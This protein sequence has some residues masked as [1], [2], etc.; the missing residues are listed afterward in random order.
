MSTSSPK[1]VSSAAGVAWNLSALFDAPDDPRIDKSI[2][3]AQR[4]AKRF[5]ATW[6]GKIKGK[7][8]AAALLQALREYESIQEDATRIGA[9]AHLVFAADTRPDAHRQLLQRVEAA[10]T[11]LRNALLFFD[12]EWLEVPEA[13]VKK[14]LADPKLAA[15]KHYLSSERKYKPHT[16]SEPEEVLHNEK[17]M[18]G[19]S[20][21]QKLHTELMAGM[22]FPVTLNGETRDLNQ[23]EA[24]TLMRVA[25]RA[26]RRAAWEGFYNVLSKN[27]QV[28]SYIY[29]TRFNDYLINNRLR[30]FKSHAQPRHLANSIEGKAVD[31]MMDVVKN[32]HAIAH[33]YWKLKARL[34]GMERIEL[35]DQYAP[36]LDVKETIGYHDAQRLILDAL[37]RFSPDFSAMA[38]RFFDNDWIDADPR[39]GKRGGAFCA[40]VTPSTHPVILM[41]YN[42]SLRDVMTLAHELGHGMHDLLAARQTLLNYHPSLPVAETA[43][44]FAEMLVFDASLAR[45]KDDQDRLA[46]ICSKIEDSFSTV[47][48]QVVITQFEQEAYDARSK[49]RVSGKDLGEIWLRVN[50]AYYG[51]A[52][53]MTP[54][55]EWGWSYI[56]HMINTPFYCYAYA[57]GDL[58]V[59]ALYGMYRREGAGFIP[60]YKALLASGGSRTPREQTR[61]MGV[62]IQK[63]EF[64]QIGFDEMSRLVGEA[65]RLAR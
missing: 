49:G 10:G 30:R 25:D 21:W 1:P 28:L 31:V 18:T 39:D 32:N 3:A 17:A 64:W 48:R 9:Y 36:L 52:V 57:F 38:A 6:R 40:G 35:Y 12:L 24:L 26:Q 11:A 53:A 56:P 41:S 15:Y 22:R 42:D 13:H 33:R 44:V 19:I 14:L 23:G 2:A 46:L 27:S 54:G 7:P 4:R 16:L 8:S 59:K 61:A 63:A 37:E 58:L 55:Y 50:A 47:F 43:S 20:A 60:K 51:D 65:E 62:D 29:D 45:M 34:L 5:A